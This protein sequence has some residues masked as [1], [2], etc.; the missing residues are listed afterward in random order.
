M[1]HWQWKAVAL[2]V[3]LLLAGCEAKAPPKPLTVVGWGGSS[4]R[5]HRDAYWTSFVVHTGIQLHEDTWHGGLDVLRQQARSGDWDV[6]QVEVEELLLGCTEGLFER[7]DWQALGGRET[8]IE[9]SVQDCGVGAMVW[10]Q[11]FGYDA[12]RMPN[13]PGNWAE[14]WDVRRFPGRRGLRRTPKYTLEFALMADGVE[15]ADVYEVLRTKE[16]VDRAFRKLDEIKPHAVWWTSIS[17]VPE[18]LTSGQVV[19]SVT[20]PG[21]LLV[22]N[23]E[24]GR[25]FKVVWDGNIYAVDFWVIMRGSQRKSQ[26]LRLV[27]YMKQ[28]EHEA[29]LAHFI[30]TGLSNRQAIASLDPALLVDTPSNAQNLAHALAL[31]GQFWVEHSSELTQRFNAWLESE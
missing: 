2:I 18:L 19:A 14:F 29:R 31:D 24:G 12:D 3:C 23:R 1:R 22:A 27:R 21:R 8:F 16:G 7:I 30:P 11:L 9:P 17:Q 13:G 10:S 26:A 5:A 4:Q 15:P 25:N 20:S 28:P 6:V